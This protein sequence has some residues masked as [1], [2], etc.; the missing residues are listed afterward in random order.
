MNLGL[1]IPLFLIITSSPA[2]GKKIS[3][4]NSWCQ[5]AAGLSAGQRKL[6]QRV[7]GLQ[8]AIKKGIDKGLAE[9]ERE[10]KWNRW[11]C[12]LL[13]EKSLLQRAPDG[14]K[15][16]AFTTAILSAALA[17]NV[18]K[19]CTTKDV[20]ECSCE[21]IKRSLRVQPWKWKGCNANIRFGC[22]TAERFMLSGRTNN[23]H[24]NMMTRH[25][26][27]VGLEVLK[28]NRVVECIVGKS[29]TMKACH[30]T[31][32]SLQKISRIIKSKYNRATEVIAIQREKKQSFYLRTRGRDQ[33]RANSNRPEI[34]DLVFLM[35]SPSYCYQQDK[36]RIPGT[37]G[38][39]CQRNTHKEDDCNFMCCGRGHHRNVSHKRRFCNCSKA[40][41]EPCS[42]KVCTDVVI[43]N[44]CV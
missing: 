5:K 15:E 32:P 41:N 24:I 33:K 23:S 44:T 18:A 2:T 35:R 10:F 9:C 29:G 17:Y 14:T 36:Y 7:P 34:S 11:N 13:G 6:C 37:R 31:L 19:A 4:P 3:R 40:L 25:N 16:A 1:V 42:C 12:T 38:R 8:I 22:H 21:G 20:S 27:R 26:V 43:E 30:M 39:K 28:E